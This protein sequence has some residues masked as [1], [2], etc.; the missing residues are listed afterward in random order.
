MGQNIT[1]MSASE[2][3]DDLIVRDAEKFANLNKSK[4]EYQNGKYLSKFLVKVV[5]PS[6]VIF[7]FFSFKTCALSQRLERT[8]IQKITTSVKLATWLMAMGFVHTV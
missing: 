5:S 8:F 2:C 1:K 7:I 3:A 4:K 6:L